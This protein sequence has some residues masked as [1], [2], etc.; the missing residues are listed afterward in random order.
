MRS[1]K[2]SAMMLL[3][4]VGIV[5]SVAAA[6]GDARAAGVELFVQTPYDF[7]TQQFEL[8]SL[9]SMNDSSIF[10]TSAT[11]P[12]DKIEAQGKK[13]LAELTKNP[14]SGHEH[15]E[16][17]FCPDADWEV[18]FDVDFRF[19]TRGQ[20]ALTPW[21]TPT[22]NG[23]HVQLDSQVRV[24]LTAHVHISPQVFADIDFDVPVTAL[25]GIH[26]GVSLSF[27]PQIKA[28]GA[29]AHLTLDESNVDVVGLDGL[30]IGAGAVIGTGI[31]YVAGGPLAGGILG[32][33][34]GKV[35]ID[36]AKQRAREIITD[37]ARAAL[38]Q[39]N[40]MI[41]SQI[42][43]V[44]QPKIRDANN[45]LQSILAQPVPGIGMTFGQLQGTMGMSID[46]RSV[47]TSSNTFRTAVTTRFANT[48]AN[49]S[50]TA[51]MHLP[52]TVC[53]YT[54][55]DDIKVGHFAYAIG[56]APFNA[57]LDNA[58]CGVVDSSGL[59]H[60]A[61]YGDTPEHA[62]KTGL[63]G[64]DLVTWS[65]L[66]SVTMNGAPTG[67][68]T[69]DC[70]YSIDNLPNGVILDVRPEVGSEIYA[71]LGDGRRRAG[72]RFLAANVGGVPF[73]VNHAGTAV[74]ATALDLGVKGPT[75]K[76]DCPT[77]FYSSGTGLSQAEV[78][79]LKDAF[80]PEKCPACG[81]VQKPG[82]PFVYVLS[83]VDAFVTMVHAPVVV[84]P[85]AE[86]GGTIGH[87]GDP[88]FHGDPWSH[89][90]VGQPPIAG[91][92]P[93]VVGGRQFGH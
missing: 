87:A 40:E 52:K 22:D 32:A 4:A 9:E 12:Y 82:E 41:K 71:R 76:D 42:N 31:G 34:T 77:L 27:Y 51:S 43:D 46:V 86:P 72:G 57:D 84:V 66:G 30:A 55:V 93:I 50:L 14:I 39:V 56:V 90:G 17:F 60:S 54:E 61:W 18:R 80:D 63:P 10:A 45:V 89:G 64:N 69:Y 24:D 2:Q 37:K 67:T 23:A 19:P 11:I 91:L 29:E 75:T 78:D 16:A 47:T 59:R 21:G 20:P 79:R 44:L 88:L 6:P 65:T 33:I 35:A 70:A 28:E 13:L 48:P 62:L 49:R 15:C 85:G 7:D 3:A 36:A 5:A 81:V 53:V 73:V 83:N 25:I 26:G 38:D 92:P 1:K 58:G 8:D 74:D 68:D